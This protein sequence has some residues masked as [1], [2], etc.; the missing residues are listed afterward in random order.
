MRTLR[1]ALLLTLVTAPAWAEDA[2]YV[3]GEAIN[4][5]INKDEAKPEDMPPLGWQTKAQVGSTLTWTHNNNV[6]GNQ[7][8]ATTQFNILADGEL[9]W[10]GERAQWLNKLAIAYGLSKTPQLEEFVKSAD[11]TDFETLGLYSLESAPWLGPFARLR[12]STNLTPG[13]HVQDKEVEI[14]RIS[15]DGEAESDGL[16]EAQ[17]RY[18]LVGAF[19]PMQMRES[20]GFFAHLLEKKAIGLVLKAGGGIQQ[21]IVRD[22]YVLSDD[23]ATPALEIKQLEDINDAGIE[24]E[25]EAKGE[26]NEAVAWSL[27]ANFFLPLN[28]AKNEDLE[29]MEKL[30]SDIKGK[31]S[32]KLSDFASLDYVLSA[33]RVPEVLEE[34]QVQNGLVLT[35]T[36]KLF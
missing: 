18:R 6:I 8:G 4:A 19:E 21:I 7:D 20:A 5:E 11:R 14:V 26:I 36:Y 17:K 31:I 23:G 30:N 34:W 2:D 32:S 24:I 1:F 9:N 28:E 13:Y 25:A 29:G 3:P 22:G 35:L 12:L 33:K 16:L 10:R 15:A 27:L